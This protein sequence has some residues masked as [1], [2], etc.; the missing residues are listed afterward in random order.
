[1]PVAAAARRMAMARA[2]QTS[3]EDDFAGSISAAW[4]GGGPAEVSAELP[5]E[6]S[7]ELP[8]EVSGSDGEDTGSVGVA[9]AAAGV[10]LPPVAPPLLPP[11]GLAGGGLPMGAVLLPMV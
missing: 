4:A 2:V 1:M 10:A 3:Q 6:V 8:A 5:A 9:L 7:A 11:P